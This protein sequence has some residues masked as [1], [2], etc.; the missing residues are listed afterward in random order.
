MPPRD[1]VPGL[2]EQTPGRGGHGSGQA[3]GPG[4]GDGESRLG[5]CTFL[6]RRNSLKAQKTISLLAF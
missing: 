3:A 6:S 2:G 4:A 1:T 5:A